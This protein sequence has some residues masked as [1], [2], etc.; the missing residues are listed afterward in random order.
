MCTWIK[1][2]L[3]PP[4][5]PSSR[6]QDP[7]SSSFCTRVHHALG[8]LAM[9][10]RG[11]FS[12]GMVGAHSKISCVRCP[13]WL[14]AEQEEGAAASQRPECPQPLQK[15]LQELKTLTEPGTGEGAQARKGALQRFSPSSRALGPSYLPPPSARTA[16]HHPPG[17]SLLP[18]G[19]S[20]HT[21]DPPPGSPLGLL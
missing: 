16:S 17:C 5:P 15:P 13:K 1:L 4:L 3:K 18:S 11:L 20:F 21:T 2:E 10:T 9:W 6:H 19:L 12:S 7:M 8:R 14:A